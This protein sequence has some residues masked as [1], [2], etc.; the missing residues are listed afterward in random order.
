LLATATSVVEGHPCAC[1][2]HGLATRLGVEAP[3]IREVHAMLYD[4][5][6][7]RRAVQDLLG[8]DTKAED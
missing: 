1:S 3:I 2:A 4:D 6:E 5:K 8:R 7:P